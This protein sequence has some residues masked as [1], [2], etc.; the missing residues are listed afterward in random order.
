M[1]QM[2][3]WEVDPTKLKKL[4]LSGNT[5][6]IQFTGESAF[7]AMLYKSRQA[8]ISLE[9]GEIDQAVSTMKSCMLDADEL[10]S[11]DQ[12]GHKVLVTFRGER[13][14]KLGVLPVDP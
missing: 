12:E 8:W 3:A 9:E 4:I 5:H 7:F 13:S 2:A 10:L 6:S 14:V 11:L 1:K